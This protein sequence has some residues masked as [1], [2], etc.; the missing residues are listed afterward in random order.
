MLREIRTH[1]DNLELGII[2]DPKTK[3]RSD[4]TA[5]E[6]I[7]R[8]Q[9]PT[10]DGFPTSTRGDGS[11]PSSVLDDQGNPMPPVADPVGELVITTSID[12][13]RVAAVNVVRYLQGAAGD[14]RAAVGALANAQPPPL[15]DDPELEELWC[16]NHLQHHMFE[17]RM[18]TGPKASNE[19]C[20]WC[21]DFRGIHNFPP[22]KRLLELRAEGR[23]ITPQQI[24]ARRKA[25]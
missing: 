11:G 21:Y 17:P 22:D 23:R 2:T 5:P 12:H 10:R 24:D 15:R 8:A 18:A 4:L 13:V 16:T 25:G 6:L 1:L 9:Q 3:E 14:L 19:L 7:R 20:R